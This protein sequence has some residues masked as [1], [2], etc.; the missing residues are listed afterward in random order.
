MEGTSRMTLYQTLEEAVTRVFCAVENDRNRAVADQLSDRY[1]RSRRNPP[2]D[3]LRRGWPQAACRFSD[4][5][6]A[7]WIFAARTAVDP[8][9]RRAFP[10]VGPV[11]RRAGRHCRA[12]WIGRP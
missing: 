7:V 10:A 12:G 3:A 6:G 1:R 2:A 11:A 5:A 8:A 4:V 9:A